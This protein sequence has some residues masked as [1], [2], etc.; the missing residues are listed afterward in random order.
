VKKLFLLPFI[1]LLLALVGCSAGDPVREDFY[2]TNINNSGAIV[3]D[4]LTATTVADGA[5]STLTGGTLTSTN[6]NNS[7]NAN[8]SGLPIFANNAAAVAGGLAVGDLYRTNGDPD[9]IAVV[10]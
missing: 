8:F 5:G 6:I 10:H 2:T 1:L 9:L 7:G 4:S 3:T